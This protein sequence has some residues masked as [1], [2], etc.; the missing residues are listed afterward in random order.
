MDPADSPIA[1]TLPLSPPNPSINFWI[2]RNAFRWSLSARFEF[3]DSGVCRYPS[4]PSR[5]WTLAP[6]MGW[7]SRIDCSTM[8]AV[9][10][11][12]STFPKMKPPPWMYTSTGSLEGGGLDLRYE[13][14]TLTWRMRQSSSSDGGVEAS[15]GN[16]PPPATSLLK[17]WG[18]A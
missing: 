8:S 1:V 12:S 4:A 7:L 16:G 3:P 9:L 11:C 5:Y 14:G 2:Q 10:C 17:V 13:S 6:M 18:H 15:P